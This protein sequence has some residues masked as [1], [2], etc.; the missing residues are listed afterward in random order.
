MTELFP[1]ALALFTGF[2]L[3]S[4]FDPSGEAGPVWAA[5]LFRFS[6]G[7][8]AGIGFSSTVYFV[9]LTIGLA[10]PWV[11]LTVEIACA[12]TLALFWMRHR[13]GHAVSR[14]RVVPGILSG[15]FICGLLLEG[16]RLVQISLANPAGE[17]DASAIW[18]LRAKFLTDAD[19]WRLVVSPL[20]ATRPEYPLLISSF[21]ARGW[22]M[23]GD[24]PALVPILTG[25][26][27]WAALPGLMVSALAMIRG[28]AAGMFGGLILLSTAPLF[29]WAAAQ[30]ADI[31]LACYFLATLA[32]LFI[33][34]RTEPRH[35]WGLVWA[36]VCAGLAAG[37]KNE[38]EVFL[39]ILTAAFL[40][41]R[42]PWRRA[43]LLFAGMLPALLPLVCLKLFLPAPSQL[44]AG[45][46]VAGVLAKIGDPGRYHL[47]GK[48]LFDRVT[49][50]GSGP[51]HPLILMAFLTVLLSPQ[52]DKRYRSAVWISSIAAAGMLLSYL[53]VYV[54]TPLDLPWHLLT[55]LDR[56]L[57]QIWPCFVLLF[58]RLMP[59]DAVFDWR[60]NGPSRP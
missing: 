12:G 29:F 48:S 17:W 6:L 40:L 21:I 33:D 49:E 25:L 15:I 13:G 35:P 24:Y 19:N 16:T 43:R 44:F 47:I 3:V 41:Q 23:A 31:P 38:G 51:G 50:L 39:L 42:P 27:F 32:L 26:T 57:I 60:T 14:V 28:T 2:L 22:K 4:V 20:L 59:D 11:V 37:T 36:G 30:Y 52:R 54:I 56:V 18:N 58:C 45:Q 9:L 1:F 53:A 55:S 7:S 46:T 5:L 10:R 34:A 8:V